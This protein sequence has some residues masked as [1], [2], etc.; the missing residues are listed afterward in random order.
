MRCDAG[1]PWDAIATTGVS[2]SDN[3][4][5]EN[6]LRYVAFGRK[7]LF[8]RRSDAGANHAAA[9]CS[10]LGIAKLN[11]HNPEA[12]LCE[13]LARI[14]EHPIAHVNVL[15]PWHLKATSTNPLAGNDATPKLP[16]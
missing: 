3:N 9:I 13:V 1:T 8:V 7:E 11:G 14:A 16:P 5:A 2:R 10:L 6:V 4:A 12:S 15:L